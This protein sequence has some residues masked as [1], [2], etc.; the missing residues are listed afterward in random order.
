[1]GNVQTIEQAVAK[2]SSGLTELGD[3]MQDPTAVSFSDV[4][5]SMEKLDEA[6]KQ[7][8]FI[9]VVFAH[10]VARDGGS[11]VVG[12]SRAVDY[13][14][15]QLGMPYG[16]AMS[17]LDAARRLFDPAPSEPA[18]EPSPSQEDDA[19]A[20]AAAAAA[21][22]EKRRREEARKKAQAEARRRM[23]EQAARQRTIEM[24]ERELKHLNTHAQPGHT[25]L[26]N[27]A[28]QEAKKRDFRELQAWL[29]EQIRRANA[30]TRTPDGTPDPFAALRKRSLW[31]SKPDANGGV[32][33]GGYLDAATAAL[34]A[35]ALSPAVRPG[36]PDLPPEEDKRTTDQ[37]RVDQ[38]AT[39][40]RGH[41]ADKDRTT[42]GAGSLVIT[43]TLK[44]LENMTRESVF[45]TATGH[46]LTPT[47]V[48][49]LG[50][51]L[52][53]YLLITDEDARPLAFGRARRTASLEQKLALIAMEL[54]CTHPGCTA[55]ATECDVHHLQAWYWGGVTDL[56]NLTL[57]CRRHHVDNN[58]ARNGAGGMGHAERDPETGRVGYQPPNSDVLQFNESPLAEHSSGHKI[59]TD[60]A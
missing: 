34:L 33:I 10:L 13:F 20:A 27:Q 12:S 50:M 37:R 14:T 28:L 55:P 59:R 42:G 7:K 24:I 44:D 32:R 4:R 40:L 53:D 6:L 19:A 1:M 31:M 46:L 22:E 18:A 25:E 38:L 11:R 60:A 9:D 54:C 48:L 39:I 43:A 5:V 41:L 29:R 56:K 8:T 52:S 36:G 35:Q 58:D 23:R 49:R 21:E 26:F 57:L 45:P 2:I 47:D 51:G 3:A 15:K 17:L 30:N 16:E